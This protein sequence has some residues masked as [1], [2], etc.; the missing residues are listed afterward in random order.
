[1]ANYPN[2]HI[3]EKIL[4]FSIIIVMILLLLFY[5]SFVYSANIDNVSS[6]FMFSTNQTQHAL[7]AQL[8]SVI[9]E[10]PANAS[11]LAPY[12]T[13]PQLSNREY[14]E[15]TGYTMTNWYFQPQYI[16]IDV[17]T[18]ISYNANT[19]VESL[20]GYVNPNASSYEVY[21]KNGSAILLKYKGSP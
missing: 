17:N 5:P 18:T 6:A 9:K 15:D 1:M 20:I 21:A 12:F 11:V 7:Y 14:L 13:T 4:A 3:S 19:G 8:D 2:G 10:I 16:L